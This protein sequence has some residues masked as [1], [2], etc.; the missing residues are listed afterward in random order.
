MQ[1]SIPTNRQA[2]TQT[3]EHEGTRT[4]TQGEAGK[5][6]ERQTS[7]EASIHPDGHTDK[8]RGKASDS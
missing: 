7:D 8:A 2:R 5:Q 1:T 3:D 4:H 6:T